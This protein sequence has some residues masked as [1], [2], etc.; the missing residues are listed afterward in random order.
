[1]LNKEEIPVIK[2]GH[3]F[4]TGSGISGR[5]ASIDLLR[6]WVIVIMALDHVRDYFHG[7]SFLHEPTD[8]HHTTAPIFL[9]RWITHFCAPVFM[10]LA[11]MSAYLYGIKNGRKALSVFLLTRGIWLVFAE[12]FLITFSWSFHPGYPSFVLQVIWAFGLSM[13]VLSALI[14]LPR[15]VL[16]VLST[17]LIL[18]HNILDSVH[19][20]GNKAGAFLWSVLHEPSFSGFHFGPVHLV[21][22][23]PILPYI[24]IITFGYCLGRL[25]TGDVTVKLRKRTLC[26]LGVGAIILFLALRALNIY[27]DAAHWTEQ[28]N[29]LFTILSFIDTTKYPPSLLY[30]LMT[31]GPTFLFLAF[32]E[33]PLSRLE[34][35]VLVFGNVP[36]FFYLLHIPLIH[37]LAVIAAVLLGYP[38]TEMVNLTGWVN[39][40]PGL[41]GYGFSLFI[42]YLIWIGVLVILFPVCRKFQKYKQ[43]HQKDKWWLRYI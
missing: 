32:T 24:G 10:L 9:T 22:V 21:V 11:G 5:I 39:A 14:R 7:Y 40:N 31:L 13:I 20:T 1:M 23:Y 6:G 4:N 37:G 16:W 35:K 8:L 27:G 43:A 41:A 12:M 34:T 25:F 26:W 18:G 28:K 29:I 3:K 17:V 38:A 36:M 2:E 15:P 19:I 33:R 42:V 30:I